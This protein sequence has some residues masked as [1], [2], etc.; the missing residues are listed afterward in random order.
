MMCEEN[1]SDRDIFDLIADGPGLRFLERGRP[2]EV[3]GSDNA[4]DA[5]FRSGAA[6]DRSSAVCEPRRGPSSDR[7]LRGRD[8]CRPC[9][10]GASVLADGCSR[11]SGAPA[12]RAL[13]PGCGPVDATDCLFDDAGCCILASSPASGPRNLATSAAV[14]TQRQRSVL[15]N[16][17]ASIQPA[18]SDQIAARLL[19]EF[20]SLGRIWTQTPEALQRIL[21][22]SSPIPALLFAARDAM[23]EGMRTGLLGR[24]LKPTNQKLLSYLTFSMGSLPDEVLRVLFLDGAQRLIADEQLQHGT[25]AQ[26]AFY[27]RVILRRAMEHDAAAIILVHNHPSGD[28]TPSEQ[29]VVATRLLS[30]LAR[31]LDIKLIEHIIV[32]GSDYALIGKRACDE[33]VGSTTTGYIL[34]DSGLKAASDHWPNSAIAL[35][36]AKRTV[37]RRLLRRQVIGTPK[38]FGEP[39]WDMLIDLFI[40]NGEGRRLSTSDLCLSS[41][42]PL[43]SALRL[44]QQLCDEKVLFKVADKDDGRRQFVNLSPDIAWKLEAYFGAAR[45]LGDDHI[46]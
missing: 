11:L 4:V 37:R 35:A 46:R 5:S 44:V 15:A 40:E 38:L 17:I 43:S 3:H 28:P 20:R 22:R 34:R 16:F 7:R 45:E 13:Q 8:N 12:P 26:L 10:G 42:L 33:A 1:G 27:P 36:N 29:D 19:G 2:R 23:T 14:A 6:L 9:N 21:G 25:L 24:P 32:A 39:A 41:G 30:G 31:A 18:E